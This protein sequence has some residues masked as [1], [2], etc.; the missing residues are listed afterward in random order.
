M[1]RQN[2]ERFFRTEKQ[3]QF[4]TDFFKEADNYEAWDEIDFES[5]EEIP[6]EQTF[7]IT[8]EDMKY[9]AEAVLDDNPLLNDEGKAN[10]VDEV[11]QGAIPASAPSTSLPSVEALQERLEMMER[12]LATEMAQW[13]EGLLSQ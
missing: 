10:P 4:D 2:F 9:Y 1:S 7:Q 11:P 6:G 5:P 8:A 12:Q 13:R 3:R